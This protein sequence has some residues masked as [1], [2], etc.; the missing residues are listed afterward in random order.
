MNQLKIKRTRQNAKLPCRATEGSAGY[1]L[2]AAVESPVFLYPQ[3]RM[4][5]ATGIAMEIE[6]PQIVGYIFARS[7]LAIRQGLIPANCVGVI[8]SD[9]RGEIMIPLMNLGEE[10]IQISEGDRIAQLVFSPVFLP[11]LTECDSLLETERGENG[12]GSTGKS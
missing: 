11:K 7:G 4:L 8:D 1:D 5:I 10:A 6:S 12:F 3:K 2:F 9:Y